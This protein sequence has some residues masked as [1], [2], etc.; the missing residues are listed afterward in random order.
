M[1]LLSFASAAR[2]DDPVT[3][4][5]KPGLFELR[6]LTEVTLAAVTLNTRCPKT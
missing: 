5:W 1:S 3:L 4:Q 2:F 6:N